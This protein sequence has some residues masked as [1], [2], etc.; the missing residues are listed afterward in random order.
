MKKLER[1]Q[2]L[3]CSFIID[4]Q[5]I[6]DAVANQ[7]PQRNLQQLVAQRYQIGINIKCPNCDT[8][9]WIP[10]SGKNYDFFLS[11]EIIH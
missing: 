11:A 3:S 8:L 2:C 5:G 1:F 7:Y 10:G 6:I 4:E 9:L